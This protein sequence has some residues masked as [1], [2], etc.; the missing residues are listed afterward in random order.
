MQEKGKTRIRTVIVV[1]SLLLAISFLLLAGIII[2][3]RN[4]ISE[5]VSVTAPDNVI[6]QEDQKTESW[7]RSESHTV[8]NE[9]SYAGNGV[10]SVA[11]LSASGQSGAGANAT[12]LSLYAR[13]PEDNVPFQVENMFPGDSETNDYCVQVSHKGNVTLRFCAD[14]RTGYEKLA[15]V[16]KCRIVLTDSGTVLYEGLMRDMPTSLNVDL[17][18][19]ESKTS[20]VCYEISAYLDTSVGNDYMDKTLIADF[21][22][23]VEETG[24]L[25]TPKTGDDSGVLLW[26]VTAAA[27]LLLLIFLLVKSKKEGAANEG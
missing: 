9:R 27:S 17:S 8:K 14:I 25:Q 5:P 10:A 19:A 1:L 15:E 18:A 4:F 21:R 6:T 3:N 23:W 12:A 20:E 24:E 22:W 16:L 13:H 11:T 26:S 7:D 2:R